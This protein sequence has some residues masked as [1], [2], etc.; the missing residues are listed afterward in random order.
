MSVFVVKTMDKYD[1]Q[2]IPGVFDE[3]EAGYARI[4]WSWQDNQDLRVINDAREN[5]EPLDEHQ[6]E[7]VRCIRFLT[8]P[9]V[10]DYLIYPHQ[11]KRN[12]FSVVE[13]VGDYDYD[14]EGGGIGGD[15]RSVRPCDVIAPNI[16]IYDERVPSQFRY[17]LGRPGR[18]SQVYDTRPFDS[19]IQ[20]WDAGEPEQLQDKTNAIRIRRIHNRLRNDLPDALR[21]EFTQADLSRR[22]SAELFERMGFT[23]V[24]QEGPNEAG[25]D[26][27]VTVGNPLLIDE[28]RIGV[29]AFAYE[30]EVEAAKFSEKL[31]Q[32]VKGWETNNLD[33]G[34]LL[35]TANCNDEIV[36]ILDEHNRNNLNRQIK[37]IDG[38]GLADLFLQY[39]AP[40]T[41]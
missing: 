26:L 11:P 30:G 24:V 4:G 1:G 5:G 14:D 37:L 22:F 3:L 33:F 2:P 10:G 16:D 41:E 40:G 13:V 28:H 8:R 34:V 9:I 7:A 25:S 18:F 6:Q 27:V 32:L 19:L 12:R 17:R 36:G 29:Q 20:D 23:C 15:F 31:E 39:F 35:T 21:M 38:D